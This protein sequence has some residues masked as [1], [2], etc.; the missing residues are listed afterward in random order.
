MHVGSKM[1]T[2]IKIICKIISYYKN[3]VF[4]YFKVVFIHKI[5]V[6]EEPNTCACSA[7]L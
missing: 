7:L 3:E 4:W 1:L 6:Y 2:F 5:F